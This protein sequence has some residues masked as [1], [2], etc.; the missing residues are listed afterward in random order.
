[1]LDILVQS[2]RNAA[3]VGRFFRRLLRR[4]QYQPRR[5]ILDGLRSYGVAQ[6]EILSDITHRQSRYL[7]NQA[8]N[9]HR[10]TRQR[11]RQMQW[12]KSPEQGEGLPVG[13]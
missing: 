11:E 4:P 10:P 3:A 2:R 8:E 6:R 12:F 9:S 13:P 7:N 5:I 1:M